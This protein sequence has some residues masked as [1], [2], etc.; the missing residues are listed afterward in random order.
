M[1]NRS[2]EQDL[3]AIVKIVT[4]IAIVVIAILIASAH[5]L[6]GLRGI[7]AVPPP[8]STSSLPSGS[9]SSHVFT[10]G[11]HSH[12]GDEREGNERH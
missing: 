1:S 2:H 4:I 5:P 11:T 12:C 8:S 3:I 6:A 7:T 9:S 10:I